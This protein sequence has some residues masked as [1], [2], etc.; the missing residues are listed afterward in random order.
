M[1]LQA[2]GQANAYTL[3]ASFQ[4]LTAKNGQYCDTLERVYF[5]DHEEMHEYIRPTKD[6]DAVKNTGLYIGF[7]D[8]SYFFANDQ[9]QPADWRPTQRGWYEA[10]KDQETFVCTEPYIDA[11][12]NELCVTYVRNVNFKNGEFG[13]AAI[14]VFL[15]E[16]QERVNELKP[17][18][19]G[20]SMVIN[21]D[22]IISYFDSELNGTLVSQSGRYDSRTDKYGKHQRIHERNERRGC[23]SW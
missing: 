20:G 17:M 12:T 15:T 9:T 13:V 8:D 19:T 1:D 4:M 16:L 22:Y 2:E 18:K 23:Y 3:G 5:E 14:D 10:G 7:S 11:A 21:G 6:Y